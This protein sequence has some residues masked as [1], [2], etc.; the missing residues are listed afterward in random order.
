MVRAIRSV[1]DEEAIQR[2]LELFSNTIKSLNLKLSPPKTKYIVFGLHPNPPKLSNPL[3]L[4]GLEID[5]V[6]CHRYLGVLVDRRL[7]FVQQTEK[8]C[9]QAKKSI[10]ALLR[11]FRSVCP[12]SVLERVYSDVILPQIMYASE[13]WFPSS[14]KW[15]T[16]LENVQHFFLKQHQNYFV[17][18]YC[19]LGSAE[20]V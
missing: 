9:I 14:Q 3:S 12:L 8:V 13:I 19:L 2:D 7:S 15:R 4:D 6:E 17:R 16:K 10:G 5:Q 11:L 1:E 18:T 20:C